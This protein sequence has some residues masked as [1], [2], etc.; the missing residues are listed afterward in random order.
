MKLFKMDPAFDKKNDSFVFKNLVP[1]GYENFF[2]QSKLE[3]E[4]GIP[5]RMKWGYGSESKPNADMLH[6]P[7]FGIASITSTIRSL[8]KY[9]KSSP[10]LKFTVSGENSEYSFIDLKNFQESGDLLD[11]VFMMYPKYKGFLVTDKFK[12]E[13][14][15]RGMTGAVFTQVAEMD[16]A[17]FLKLE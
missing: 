17:Q 9:S 12:N 6:F 2:F 4:A 13:W 16:D 3:I 5:L 8:E 15:S 7:F 10:V 1:D 14:E 11:H